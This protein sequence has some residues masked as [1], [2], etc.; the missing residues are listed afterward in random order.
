MWRA[1]THYPPPPPPPSPQQKQK[2]FHASQTQINQGTGEAPCLS[3]DILAVIVCSTEQPNVAGSLRCR[4][5]KT[6]VIMNGRMISHILKKARV[7]QQATSARN[8]LKVAPNSVS[9][10]L[11]IRWQVGTKLDL[12]Q[13]D[14]S[15]RAEGV[16]FGREAADHERRSRENIWNPT[17]DCFKSLVPGFQLFKRRK[18]LSTGEISIQR[19]TQLVYIYLLDFKVLIDWATFLSHP[20]LDRPSWP[21]QLFRHENWSTPRCR[22]HQK[23]LF[24][25]FVYCF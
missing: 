15:W 5:G 13:V 16:F 19:M 23:V 8:A 2:R 1:N 9:F 17:K 18:L 14:L 12:L 11:L 10:S 20:C 3:P 21:I 22:H 25:L 6:K 24:A 4:L 7:Q